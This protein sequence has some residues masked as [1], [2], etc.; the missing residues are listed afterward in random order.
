MIPFTQ[1]LRP[2]GRTRPMTI[3]RPA[4]IEEKAHA[5]IDLGA[6]FE[7]EELM[8]GQVSMTCELDDETDPE[9]LHVL[10]H[11]ICANGPSVIEAVDTL[12]HRSWEHMEVLTSAP[13]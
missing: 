8:T 1:Y 13:V 5:L 3:D 10:G 4:A 11:E 7:I 2:N 6:R 12:I 9:E